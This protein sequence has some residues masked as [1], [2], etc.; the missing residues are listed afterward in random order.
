MRQWRVSGGACADRRCCIRAATHRADAVA[1]VTPGRV[2]TAHRQPCMSLL[3]HSVDRIIRAI[4]I[5]IQHPHISPFF[6]TTD[7][8][9]CTRLPHIKN[10]YGDYD[11]DTHE[12]TKRKNVVHIKRQHTSA[13]GHQHSAQHRTTSSCRGAGA[14][15][16]S[17]KLARIHRRRRSLMPSASRQMQTRETQRHC[18]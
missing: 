5:S 17:R 4:L 9:L 11:S 16:R 12:H 14:P 7:G 2:T 1:A 15:K 10:I 8:A 6:S 13:I 3:L 18:Q